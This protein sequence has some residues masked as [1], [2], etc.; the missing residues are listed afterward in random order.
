MIL[1]PAFTPVTMETVNKSQSLYFVNY[2]CYSFM[3]TT[4]LSRVFSLQPHWF[5]CTT[6]HFEL[7]FHHAFPNHMAGSAILEIWWFNRARNYLFIA[8]IDSYYLILVVITDYW[9]AFDSLHSIK[10][11]YGG[12]FPVRF[13]LTYFVRFTLYAAFPFYNYHHLHRLFKL[14]LSK[15]ITTVLMLLTQCE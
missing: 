15:L 6:T 12:P 11:R 10:R 2:K 1:L 9:S 13:N 8:K 4:Q 7:L 14:F 5:F 3:F